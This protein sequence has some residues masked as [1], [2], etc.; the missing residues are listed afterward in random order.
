MDGERH[1]KLKNIVSVWLGDA[2]RI[3]Q[4]VVGMVIIFGLCVVPCLYAWFN[5]FSNWDPY[6]TDATSQIKVAVTSKDKGDLIFGIGLNIGDKVTEALESNKSI[7]W[8]FADSEQEARALVDSGDCYAAMIIPE[9]FTKN[10]SSFTDLEFK[11]PEI[12]YYENQKKNAIAPKIT[13]KAKTAVQQQVNETFA[14]TVV[15]VVGSLFGIMDQ[16]GIDYET[17][18]KGLSETVDNLNEKIDDSE[19]II[20]S[21]CKLLDAC[22]NLMYYSGLLAGDVADTSYQTAALSHTVATDTATLNI[23]IEALNTTLKEMLEESDS[24]LKTVEDS[25]SSGQTD[26]ATLRYQGA[27][28][29]TMASGIE[30]I[31]PEIARRM[32]DIGDILTEA[33]DSGLTDE[34]RQTLLTDLPDLILDARKIVIQHLYDSITD[35]SPKLKA[36]LSNVTSAAE[37][38]AAAFL[39]ASGDAS[40]ISNTFYSII[41]PLSTLELDLYDARDNLLKAEELTDQLSETLDILAESEYLR[42]LTDTVIDNNDELAPYFASPIRMNTVV[43]YPI[44]NYGSAMAPFYVVLSQW[45][46]ALF[47]VAL[48]KARVRKEDMSMPLSMTEE[49]FGRFAL[50]LNVGLIQAIVTAAGCLWY[51]D[52]YC[53][54]PLEF[55][56]AA[57][58]TGICFAAINFALLFSL[59]KIGLGASVIIMV[60]QVAGAGGSYPVRVLPQIFQKL[61]PFMP[62][63]YAMNAMREAI[64]GTYGNNYE[65]YIIILLLISILFAVLGLLLYKPVHWL[66]KLIAESSEKAEIMH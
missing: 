15:G 57:I 52:I 5:I 25:I 18:I 56:L 58:V 35:L 64:G 48:L 12:T 13:G 19:E 6:G 43:M 40:Q 66:N 20:S 45:V 59:E 2:K 30:D 10:V 9:D 60:I 21:V 34:Q 4:N 63:N 22:E 37:S 39:G 1:F 28:M 8:V 38:A 33:G 31:D 53:V 27:V 16:N 46:G 50:F 42:E 17:T 44:E 62:F 49:F 3:F 11:H 47:A 23:K 36:S 32:S 41:S 14:E 65:K 29:G 55:F 61:Y 24:S 51:I 7:G 26:S 54:H